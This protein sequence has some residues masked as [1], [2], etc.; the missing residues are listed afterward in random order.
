MQS[1]ANSEDG[2]DVPPATAAGKMRAGKGAAI[3]ARQAAK[4]GV[5]KQS[6]AEIRARQ[7]AKQSLA[8][9]EDRR[10]VPPATALEKM[11]VK[12]GVKRKR[13]A[14]STTD[15]EEGRDVVPAVTSENEPGGPGTLPT[16]EEPMSE[17]LADW[18]NDW[19]EAFAA[20]DE[21]L[22]D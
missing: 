18:M 22:V 20:E 6:L 16:T 21:K 9:S 11:T 3:R 19:A 10:D 2:G 13:R 14:E 15:S 8:D 5:A 17:G 7:A 4:K 12:Q 1:L